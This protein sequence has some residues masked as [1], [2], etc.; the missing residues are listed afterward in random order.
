VSVHTSC[1][2]LALP[3]RSGSPVIPKAQY[4]SI[5]NLSSISYTSGYQVVS[6]RAL[7]VTLLGQ[8]TTRILFGNVRARFVLCEAAAS[9][10]QTCLGDSLRRFGSAVK[11]LLE[12]LGAIREVVRGIRIC[13]LQFAVCS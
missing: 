4:P 10:H 7:I 9:T 6:A 12:Y 3:V 13:F 8:L 1:P 5:L 11:L 2:K